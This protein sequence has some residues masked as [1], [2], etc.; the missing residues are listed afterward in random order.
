M[1]AAAQIASPF[2]T[3][4]MLGELK[5]SY[6]K[7]MFIVSIALVAKAIALPTLG[8]LAQRFGAWRLLW[9][10]G[11]IVIPMPML[12]T[13]SQ[14][15]PM[16]LAIQLLSGAAWATY[17]LG[18]FLLFF[19][20]I[21]PRQRIPMLTLYNLGYAAATVVGSLIGGGILFLF[22]ES[23]A[24]Y[25]V[26]FA[27]SCAARIVILPLLRRAGRSVESDREDELP[28]S[29]QMSNKLAA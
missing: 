27:A 15:T 9:I 29:R 16:L 14:A 28:A 5:F 22:S 25:M 6:V 17:E 3:P 1:Q 7:F 18:A 24:G 20:A 13:I 21:G 23:Y 8:R 26:V 11:V 2:F 10:G 19:E 12:W 4:F